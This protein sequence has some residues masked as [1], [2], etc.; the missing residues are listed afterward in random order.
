MLQ[1]E[2][3][4]GAFLTYLTPSLSRFQVIKKLVEGDDPLISIRLSQSDLA[5]FYLSLSN[6]DYERDLLLM[7]FDKFPRERLVLVD[8]N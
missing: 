2:A 4:E 6:H 5:T 3:G 1:T 7:R 8:K